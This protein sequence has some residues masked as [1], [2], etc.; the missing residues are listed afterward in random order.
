MS[1]FEASVPLPLRAERV[2]PP[3][4][5]G[6]LPP[7]ADAFVAR[8]ADFTQTDPAMAGATVLGAIAACAGGRAEVEAAPGWVE[9]TNLYVATVAHP[10]ERKSAVLR[11]VVEPIQAVERELVEA[12][13]P[14]IAE[15]AVERE[16][17]QRQADAARVAAAKDGTADAMAEAVDLATV[18]DTI[19]VPSLPRL[20]A[21]DVTPEALGSL[22]AEQGGRIAVLSAE[23]GLF[24]SLAGRY[25][26]VPN[27]DHLLKGYSG[28]TIRVDRKGRAAEYVDRPA[29]TVVLMMQ[30]AVLRAIA[31]NPAFRGR[32]LVERFWWVLPTSKV[33]RRDV[34]PAPVSPLVADAYGR[35]LTTLA[36]TLAGWTDPAR[37]TL[38]DD[39]RALLTGIRRDVES[40]L[41]PGSSLAALPAWGS[42]L[43]GGAVRLSGLLALADRPA[44]AGRRHVERRHVESAGRLVEWLAGHALVAFDAMG[45]DPA[46]DDARAL[47][48]AVE[49]LGAPEV[50]KRDLF[51]AARGRF[52][53]VAELE[54]ALDVLVSHGWLELKPE[55][56]R[57]GPGRPPSPTYR[58]HPQALTPRR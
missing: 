38:A 56:P 16:V 2:V 30:P 28:D 14:L 13:R 5:V 19:A 39:A 42:K 52:R 27:L 47:L 29:L 33:G 10:G 23:G 32:G 44:E 31:R 48:A 24:D 50:S 46:L 49:R 25:S 17:R 40:W 4:P 26:G 1:T 7:W 43:G 51:N 15:A 11:A 37:L 55:P 3:W 18:L 54:P 21:D 22:L 58:V 35:E 9:P 34:D 45:T 12:A 6:V 57:T 36:R 53:T 20:V 8:L 41:A